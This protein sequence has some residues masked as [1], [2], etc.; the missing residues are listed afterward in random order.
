MGFAQIPNS[1]LTMDFIGDAAELF[2]KTYGDTLRQHFTENPN[3]DDLHETCH[4]AVRNLGVCGS[5]MFMFFIGWY[6]ALQHISR[7]K[8]E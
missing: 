6:A 1:A 2:D 4:D 7:R 8:P 5:G 3:F